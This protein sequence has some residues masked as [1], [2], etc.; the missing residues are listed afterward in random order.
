MITD[1]LGNELTYWPITLIEGEAGDPIIFTAPV[2][3]GTSRLLCTSDERVSVYVRQAGTEDDFKD[4]TRTQVPLYSPSG[5]DMSFEIYVEGGPVEGLE[6]VP[7]T[8][9]IGKSSRAGWIPDEMTIEL[10]PP[11]EVFEGP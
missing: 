3:A 2:P 8:V 5:E 11:V 9:S 7:V 4:I 10:G 1:E 6:R